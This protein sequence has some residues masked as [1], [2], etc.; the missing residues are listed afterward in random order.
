MH[1]IRVVNPARHFLQQPVMPDI[2]KVG[3]Q[4][5]VENPR[6]PLDYCFGHALDCVMCCPLGSISIRP[7][8]EVSLEYRLE[9]ELE[10][11][12]QHSVP[13]RWNRK[14]AD[15]TPVFRYLVLP[16][17]KRLVGPPDQFVP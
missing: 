17:R 14:D 9:D 6:L 8:L 10:R 4:V 1:D 13:D 11:T 7:R 3:P 12:L 2:V 16:G 15:F 5:K